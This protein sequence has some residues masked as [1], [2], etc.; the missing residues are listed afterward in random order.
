MST[1]P[2][3]DQQTDPPITAPP[4]RAKRRSRRGLYITLILLG[5]VVWVGYQYQKSKQAKPVA[6]TVEAAT[7]KTITQLVSA[8]GKVQPETEVKISPEVAGEIIELPVVDGQRVKKG[9]LLIRIKPDNYKAQVAQQEAA[10]TS[11]KA[12]SVQNHAQMVKAHTDSTAKLKTA[13]AAASPAIMP[14][15]QLTGEQQQTLTD[16]GG[17]SGADFDTAYAK[18][19][20]DAH[21][22]TLDTVKAYS[23]NGDVAP[24]KAFATTLTP[25]VAAHLN[26]A[27]AL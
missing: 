18:V 3:K 27:K 15:P 6:V 21:Q 11:A 25:I 8:T 16:L 9:D 2:Q 1:Q 17:K 23:A 13:A 12:L 14:E 5:L 20:V 10:I 4:K 19:Q 26:M 7:R 24:L 22:M